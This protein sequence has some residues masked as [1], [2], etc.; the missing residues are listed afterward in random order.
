MET[1][2]KLLSVLI[3]WLI[4]LATLTSSLQLIPQRALAATYPQLKNI[5]QAQFISYG[6]QKW[7]L[8]NPAIGYM[9]TWDEWPARQFDEDGTNAMD[10]SDPNNIAYWLNDATNGF[11][12]TLSDGSADLSWMLATD[13]DQPESDDFKVGMLTRSE[14]SVFPGSIHRAILKPSPD[15][16]TRTR[17][18]SDLLETVHLYQD[19]RDGYRLSWTV[20]NAAISLPV[21]PAIC[22]N[23]DFYVVSGTGSL[24]DPYRLAPFPYTSLTASATSVAADGIAGSTISVSIADNTGPVAGRGLALVPSGGNSVIVN[25]TLTTD[26]SGTAAFTVTDEHMES[27]TYTVRD[28]ADNFN[29]G[30]VQIN[31]H[32]NVTGVADGEFYDT[33]RTISFVGGGTATLD[34]IG[35]SSPFTVTEEGSHTLV[36]TGANTS[37]TVSFTIDKAPAVALSGPAGGTVNAP[38][39]VTVSFSESVSGFEL[40]DITVENGTVSDFNSVSA[41]VYTATIT[42]IEIGQAVTVKVEAGA[43]FD[44]TSNNNKESNTLSYVYDTAKPTVTFGGFT[45]NQIFSVAPAS[46][47]VSVSE[48]VYWVADGALLTSSNASPLIRMEKDGVAFIGYTPSYDE[49]SRKFTVTFDNPLEEGTY[50]IAVAGGVVDNA[51]H[52]T[53]DE[54]SA[55]FTLAVPIA[56]A[57]SV[58]QANFSSNGGS[59]RVTV[60]GSKLVGHSVKIYRDG[61]EAATAVINSATEATATV[62]IPSNTG[63]SAKTH[64]LTVYLNGAEVA[65]RSATVTVSGR[66]SGGSGGGSVPV[67][68]AAA[69]IDLN[70]V[71]YDPAKIDTTKPSVTLEVTPKSGSAYASIPASTL[72]RLEGKNSAFLIEIKTPYG[73]YQVPVNLASLIPGLEQLLSANQLKAEDI[74]FKIMLTDKS[75]DKNLQMALKSGLPNGKVLGTIVDFNI[76]IVVT[77][78]GQLIGTADRFSKALTRVIPMPKSLTEMPSQWGAFRYNETKG[79]F[80]FVPAIPVKLDGIQYAMIRSYSNSVYVVAENNVTFSDLQKHWAEPFVQLAAAKGLV[81]GVGGG[82]FAPNQTVTRAEFTSMLVRELARGS[83]GSDLAPY[84]DVKRGAWFYDDVATAKELGLLGFANG[85]SF[86]PNQPLTRE[87]MAS[88]LAVAVMLEKLPVTKETVSLDGYKDIG[89]V[90][91]SYLVSVRLMVKLDIMSGT[92]ND[93]FS[94]QGVSTRAQAASV[95]VRKLQAVGVFGG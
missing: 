54:A 62:A 52:N 69:A 67:V 34:D 81:D 6:G 87:E 49:S 27:V 46:I 21:R 77:K 13:W 45:D 16:W 4:F 95:L 74:S 89:D 85:T 40:E 73:S 41:S 35:V 82:K 12:K 10:P 57:I 42:P 18:S 55:G 37:E 76:E 60:T 51:R 15:L 14:W 23:P 5:P 30:T 48:G 56:S 24:E 3:A 50:K 11:L 72:T 43:V 83:K 59:A 19:P 91:P 71:P 32:A 68:P 38:F 70:G 86:K 26:A 2:R 17:S 58:N 61:T 63:S 1:N 94:P 22:L 29:L 66:S 79:K 31:F 7:I 88:M 44:G 65:G 93:K 47:E 92:G 80:E 8:V 78:T 33:D 53:L 84:D 36:V 9:T 90:N 25:P 39:P 75:G 64:T 20:I 28:A